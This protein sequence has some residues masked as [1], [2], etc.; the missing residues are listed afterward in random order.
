MGVAQLV[1]RA[2]RGRDVLVR[3]DQ[4]GQ[5]LDEGGGGHPVGIAVR[6]PRHDLAARVPDDHRRQIT[7]AVPG[8]RH[9]QR[10]ANLQRVAQ[11]SGDE[12]EVDVDADLP[13]HVPAVHQGQMLGEPRQM[14]QP[15]GQVHQGQSERRLPA[16][17]RHRR[18]RDRQ[19]PDQG[20]QMLQRAGGRPFGDR[21]LPPDVD[22]H[23][24]PRGH[25]DAGSLSS[26]PHRR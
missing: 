26:S 24:A 10:S 19:G 9:P 23:A 15:E 25:A 20:P 6:Q 22:G 17:E 18:S 4:H 12:I 11:P 3:V 1:D 5:Q 8:D 16:R 7:A 14:I 21:G 2:G 13:A